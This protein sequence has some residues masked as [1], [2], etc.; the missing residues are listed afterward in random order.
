MTSRGIRRASA[1]VTVAVTI[2]V[3]PR[4]GRTGRRL[5]DLRDGP[6][7]EGQPAGRRHG[8]PDHSGQLVLTFD[9]QQGVTLGARQIS[10]QGPRHLRPLAEK[11]RLDPGRDRLVDSHFL[12]S[13]RC[14]PTDPAIRV[15][16]WTFSQDILGV[17]VGRQ[18]LDN[19]D[20][21]GAPGARLTAA[22][23][24]HARSIS[25]MEPPPT[26][27]RSWTRAPSPFICRR[28]A[29]PTKMRV[30]TAHNS[31]PAPTAGGPYVGVEGT[32]VAL[33]ASVLD[34]GW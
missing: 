7:G 32:P 19:S 18:A 4:D 25:V 3:A 6:T 16:T 26:R 2:G 30:L 31:E 20:V 13:N 11:G 33:S 29:A 28:E 17:I 27:S 34:P 8:Q 21:L 1:P 24:P 23:T 9:E 15:G 22:H 10:V 12:D 14:N 5:R